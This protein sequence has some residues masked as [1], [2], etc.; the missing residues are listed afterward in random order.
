MPNIDGYIEDSVVRR[1]LYLIPENR[2]QDVK[3]HKNNGYEAMTES[4]KMYLYDLESQIDRL[5]EDI[6]FIAS[7]RN[8]HMKSEI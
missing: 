3:Y 5:V 1:G 7:L 2:V 4:Q 8:I 6:Y